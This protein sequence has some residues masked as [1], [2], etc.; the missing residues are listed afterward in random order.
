MRVMFKFIYIHCIYVS[1]QNM[2]SSD[3]NALKH[4]GM[5]IRTALNY[6]TECLRRELSN[7]TSVSKFNQ[8]CFEYG[9]GNIRYIPKRFELISI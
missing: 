6:Q 7:L 3:K 9:A 2:A 1:G 8:L 5:E 4:F